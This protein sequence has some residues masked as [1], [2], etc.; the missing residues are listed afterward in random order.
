ME[1][2]AMPDKIADELAERLADA[3]PAAAQR[4]RVIVTLTPGAATEPLIREGFALERRF[5]TLSAVAGTVQAK[6]VARLAGLAE[7]ELIELD[8]EMRAL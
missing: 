3:A 1:A 6:D 7:V 8:S 4:L 2:R 5:E